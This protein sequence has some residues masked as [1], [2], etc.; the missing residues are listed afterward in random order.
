MTT[1][2]ITAL[3]AIL[4]IVIV[5]IV[6]VCYRFSSFTT[7]RKTVCNSADNR[8]YKVV[9]GYDNPD[10]ASAALGRSNNFSTALIAH[11][12]RKYMTS[13]MAEKAKT[14]VF[15]AHK[16][17][18]IKRLTKHYNP[19]NIIENAPIGGVNTSYVEN[20]GETFAV[21]LR[22][23][24]SGKNRLHDD[25]ILQFVTMHELSHLAVPE[26]DHSNRFWAV[27]KFLLAEA[28][29]AGLHQPR[30]YAENPQSYCSLN[31]SYSPYYNEEIGAF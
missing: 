5:I 31:V 1:E 25:E 4:I 13:E 29:E 2:K 6:Y 27:F 14:D 21:C 20:K 17:D 7:F 26:G 28:K 11:L 18:A 24:E 30:N 23:K 12:N 9:S 19:D 10:K 8:C 15:L 16:I 22:E 3:V